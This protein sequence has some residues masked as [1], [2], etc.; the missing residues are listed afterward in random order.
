MPQNSSS[1]F[2][3]WLL[4]NLLFDLLKSA[5]GESGIWFSFGFIHLS[6]KRFTDILDLLP[7]LILSH[8]FGLT[9]LLYC[10]L[11]HGFEIRQTWIFK[12]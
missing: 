4:F 7:I 11:H 6:P 3:S 10:T 5:L 9:W 1:S 8:T 2:G 12:R